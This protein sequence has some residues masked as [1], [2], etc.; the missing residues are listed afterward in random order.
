M[1]H[2]VVAPSFLFQIDPLEKKE[3]NKKVG[4]IKEAPN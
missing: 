4:G 3:D 2:V 1:L